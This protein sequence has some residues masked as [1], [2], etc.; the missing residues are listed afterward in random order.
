MVT[1]P[2]PGLPSDTEDHS[3]SVPST[4]V[5]S[6]TVTG[7][8]GTEGTHGRVDEIEGP[9]GGERRGPERSGTCVVGVEEE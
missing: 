9:V 8:E 2:T 1:R 4:H 6:R 5:S 7:R 3:E